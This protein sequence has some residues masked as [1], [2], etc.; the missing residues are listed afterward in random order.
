MVGGGRCSGLAR[1][2]GRSW[3]LWQA[4]AAWRLRPTVLFPWKPTDPGRPCPT[5]SPLCSPHR[6]PLAGL[7]K[8]GS[9]RCGALERGHMEP[10]GTPGSPSQLS[11][12]HL[13]VLGQ[14]T[15]TGSLGPPVPEMGV[16]LGRHIWRTSQLISKG[17][18][19]GRNS[20]FLSFF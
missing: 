6:A 2:V 3:R 10:P 14:V 17:F 11:H 18:A 19:Q 12:R 13:R 7:P 16:P 15:N 20:P 1:A 5:S 4:L 8:P 9:R